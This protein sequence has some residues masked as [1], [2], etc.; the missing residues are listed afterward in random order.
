MPSKIGLFGF[1]GA[2]K[3]TQAKKL[4][5]W[6][7]IPHISTGDIFRS[8]KDSNSPLAIELKLCLDSGNLVSD[9]L[10][11]KITLERLNKSDCLNGFI[12]DG[13]PRTVF[14]AKALMASSV[15]IDCFLNINISFKVIIDRLS[16]RRLCPVC[17]QIYHIN[18]F[19]AGREIVCI[20]DKEKLIQR[21]DDKPEAISHRL[22]IFKANLLPIVDYF[23]GLGIIQNI[24]GDGNPDEVFE[25]IKNCILS[26][27]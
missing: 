1:P 26:L 27:R 7:K 14:Q 15:S 11:N 6:L 23:E 16:G 17:N 12:L 21:T 4:S 20:N 2:G 18:D 9:E 24:N 10:V 25:R 5:E 22:E 19:K 13:Y 3:G 8:L